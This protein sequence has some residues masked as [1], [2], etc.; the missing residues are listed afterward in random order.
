MSNNNLIHVAIIGAGSGVAPRHFD[1]F[2]EEMGARVVAGVENNDERRRLLEERFR[3]RIPMFDSMQQLATS[4]VHVDL[5]VVCVQDAL[6]AEVAG[7]AMVEF[8]WNV[9]CEKPLADDYRKAQMLY[10][11]AAEHGLYLGHALQRR[12]MTPEIHGL[13]ASG[14]LGQVLRVQLL[15]HRHGGMPAWRK[16]LR[17]RGGVLS[18]LG[19]HALSHGL[20]M[21]SPQRPE[22]VMA[23][24]SSVATGAAVEDDAFVLLEFLGG[25]LMHSDLA[26]DR[27]LAASTDDETL[28][29]VLGTKGSI[30]A[31]LL[32]YENEEQ[33]ALKR[34]VHL[35]TSADG[36]RRERRLEP[37]LT[38]A[39]CH[40]MQA[41]HAVEMVRRGGPAPAEERDR[42]LG[43]LW[44]ID[45]AYESSVTR[46][47]VELRP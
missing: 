9:L 19:I 29:Y 4:G 20:P 24:L 35:W 26:F 38:T 13:V 2:I 5:V 45:K 39:Q 14:D 21:F 40:L 6:H 25:G 3:G 44:L 34:P 42:E 23:M 7:R 27:P 33:A 18:D 32:T 1:S 31:S 15:W 11:A 47:W 41:R 30:R 17:A 10:K 37:L 22:R 16:Q 28:L 36:E 12:Y 43:L 8:G 46:D